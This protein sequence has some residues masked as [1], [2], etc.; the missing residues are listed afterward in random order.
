[1]YLLMKH[2]AGIN[3]EAVILAKGED[4]MRVVAQGFS[5]TLELW[6]SGTQWFDE[7][8]QPV[9]LEFLMSDGFSPSECLTAPLAAAAVMT[10]AD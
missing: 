4:R 5:D 7:D 1:M 6:H 2:A 9:D 10:A 8:H 3:L